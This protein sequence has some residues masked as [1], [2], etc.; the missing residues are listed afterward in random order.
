MEQA[1]NSDLK[2]AR[3]GLFNHLDHVL[4]VSRIKFDKEKASN[5]ERRAWGRLIV[6]AVQAYGKLL[7]TSALEELTE[8]LERLEEEVKRHGDRGSA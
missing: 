2:E 3:T 1:G 8:R 7:E 4:S 6:N 5:G